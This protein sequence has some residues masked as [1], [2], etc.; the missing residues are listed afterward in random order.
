MYKGQ[1]GVLL[2]ME[3]ALRKIIIDTGCIETVCGKDWLNDMLNIM[4]QET[5][6]IVRVFK[7]KKIFQF[8]VGER[9]ESLCQYILPISVGGMNI[10][11]VTDCINANLP[12][13]LSKIAMIKANMTIDIKNNTIKMFDDKIIN[14]DLIP[15]GHSVLNADPFIKENSTEY[16]TMIAVP[17]NEQGEMDFNRLKH[18]HEQVIIH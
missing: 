16:F 17:E 12:C 3:D 7:S 4:D 5:K 6:R 8:G 15:S 18:I 9:K 11:L 13:L 2:S 10:M 14:M 1:R